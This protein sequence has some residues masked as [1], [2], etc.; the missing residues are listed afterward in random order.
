MCYFLKGEEQDY[1][2]NKVM[3]EMKKVVPIVYRCCEDSEDGEA[4][5][6][7]DENGEAKLWVTFNPDERLEMDKH[8]EEGTL[9][10]YIIG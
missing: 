1:Y 9:L 8:I 7:C 5:V 4:V 10:E 3:E 6:G 2:V